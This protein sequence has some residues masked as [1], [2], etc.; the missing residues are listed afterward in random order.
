MLISRKLPFAVNPARSDRLCITCY[1][2]RNES[3]YKKP[4]C[5]MSRSI[6][7]MGVVLAASCLN[8]LAF[9]DGVGEWPQKY[10]TTVQLCIA[11]DGVPKSAMVITSSGNEDYD[12]AALATAK[13]FKFK[14]K[15]VDGVPLEHCVR[16]PVRYTPHSQ[17]ASRTPHE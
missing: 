8:T 13:R 1:V 15:L 17:S 6:W 4:R 16:L 10:S 11:S 14:P 3:H 7:R 5:H 12:R 2:I 9:A